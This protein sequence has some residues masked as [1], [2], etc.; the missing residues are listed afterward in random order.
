VLFGFTPLWAQQ[1]EADEAWNQGNYE[2]ARAGYERV[3][4]QNPSAARAN[5]R[6][7]I[8]LSW[9]GKLDSALTFIARARAGDPADIDMQLAQAR[10]RSWDKQY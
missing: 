6:I 3:L 10:V 7:G 8:M 9:Q 2:A 4:Q 1:R 5:L